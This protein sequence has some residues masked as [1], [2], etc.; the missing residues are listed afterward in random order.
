M[1]SQ[2]N[3]IRNLIMKEFFAQEIPLPPLEKQKEVIA[4]ISKLY[5]DANKNLTESEILN[6][7]L[8]IEIETILKGVNN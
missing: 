4:T 5:S 7:N 1:Q 6:S 3:G 8:M 2:T